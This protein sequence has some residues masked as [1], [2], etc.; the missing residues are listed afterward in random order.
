MDFTQ[1]TAGAQRF[2]FSDTGSGPLVVLVHGF[3][4][5][6]HGWA[7]TR[8][9]L[10]EAGYRTVIP[11][12]R[13]YHPDTIVPGRSYGRDAIGE[14]LVLLL[15]ALGEQ[16]AVLV[17]H[18]WGAASVYSA[19]AQFPERVRA[20][21]AVAI[22]HPSLIKPAP[23]ALWRARHF[24]TLRFPTAAK[25]MAADD[26]AHVDELMSRWAPYWSGPDRDAA[27]REVKIAFSNP[28]VLDAALAWYR[29]VRPG[30]MARITV[31]GLV[32]GGTTDIVPPDL[33]RQTPERFTA[34]CEAVIVEGA[35]HWPHREGAAVFHERLLDWLPS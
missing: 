18:D 1:A 33:F 12:L 17:G 31:P 24:I 22:P 3:P 14:D 11:Y 29:A 5:T 13:G 10:N 6:P 34:P 7:D 21:C 28:Q 32:V 19:A 9:V 20:M 30:G 8:D 35:G 26:F 23:A 27:A 2:V 25:R 16:E 4:D 15:D